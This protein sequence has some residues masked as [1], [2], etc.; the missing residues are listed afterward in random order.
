[1]TIGLPLTSMVCSAQVGFAA[2]EVLWGAIG[3]GRFACFCAEVRLE[4]VR[5]NNRYRWS[6]VSICLGN[7]NYFINVTTTVQRSENTVRLK[8]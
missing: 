2:A 1:M 7:S 8:I 4:P 3:A 5:E 6:V